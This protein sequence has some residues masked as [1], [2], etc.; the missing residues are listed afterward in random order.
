MFSAVRQR[1]AERILKRQRFGFASGFATA[2][3]AGLMIWITATL[4]LPG[5]PIDQPRILVLG[6]DQPQ[7][8]RLLFEAPA[9]IEQAS[10]SI[11]LPEHLRLQGYP[12]QRELSWQT[13]LQPGQNILALPVQA[14]RQGQGELV[15]RLSFG[16]ETQTHRVTLKTRLDGVF[17]LPPARGQSA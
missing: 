16:G 5:T 12:D 8:V 10:L 14:I 15:T 7:T 11:H 17:N 9:A 3:V 1:Y 13:S 4:F 6:L 2:V